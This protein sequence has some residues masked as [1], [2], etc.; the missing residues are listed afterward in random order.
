M[1]RGPARRC[2]LDL[3]RQTH[4]SIL[5]GPHL[6]FETA[7]SIINASQNQPLPPCS[8]SSP[9]SATPKRGRI[10]SFLLAMVLVALAVRLIVMIFLL[11]EQLD[12]A[13]DHWKFG[14]EA[15]KIA[16]SIAQGHGFA[17]PLFEDTG[18]TVWMTPVYPYLVAGVFKVFGIYT[19]TSAVVLICLNA[20]M[21]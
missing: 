19:K 15:G 20:L 7:C 21:S 17:S 14:Y 3:L 16:S 8:N 4:T 9:S 6:C 10:P 11:P 18:P 1:L 2:K 12:P 5:C 13:R